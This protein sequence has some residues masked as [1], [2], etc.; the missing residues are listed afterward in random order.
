MQ[1]RDQPP[2]A[3]PHPR[4]TWDQARLIELAERWKV[5]RLELFGSVLRD[6]FRPD[7]DVDVLVTFAPDAH[8]TLFSIYDFEQELVAL[9]GRP[10]DV[11]ERAAIERSPNYIRRREIHRNPLTIYESRFSVL[12]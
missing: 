11:V 9:F 8:V 2:S 3:A 10:V 1:E 6:D 12:A 4:I 7:S 5:A